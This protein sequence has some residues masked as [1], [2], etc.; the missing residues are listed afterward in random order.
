MR[1]PKCCRQVRA[2]LSRRGIPRPRVDRIVRELTDHWHDLQQTA[3][4]RGTGLA[5]SCAEANRKLGDPRR[6]E[7][8][9]QE[10]LRQSSWMGRHPLLTMVWMP[11]LLVPA[12][13]AIVLLPLFWLGEWL[14][15]GASPD[16]VMIARLVLG[17]HWT[18]SL[19]TSFW[20][21]CRAW[22]QGLG[23][24]W[25]LALCSYG[26]LM[27][28][29]RRLDADGVRRNISLSLNYPWPLEE[30]TVL[31]LVFHS[32]LAIGFLFL[33]RRMHK[34]LTPPRS[35]LPPLNL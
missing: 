31:I 33:A 14:L 19:L 18:L 5:E 22:R 1:E 32:L 15:A 24:Q 2:G 20:L 3:L 29:V 30:R 35:A 17:L 10:Q 27:T 9:I 12:I 28:L 6:I 13:M 7:R 4:G 8:E 23:T 11:L 16:G 21:C 26:A 34:S 25:V